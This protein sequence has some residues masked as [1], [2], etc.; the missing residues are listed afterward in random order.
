MGV[1]TCGFCFGVSYACSAFDTSV[2]GSRVL[3]PGAFRAELAQALETHDPSGD[4]VAGQHFVKLP[5]RAHRT[6]S[7]GVG[8][9]LGRGPGDFVVRAHRGRTAAFLR[10]AHA[11]QT[12]S[13]AVVV[14]TL[15]AYGS[16]PE[17]DTQAQDLVKHVEAGATH[18]IVAVLASSGPPSPHSPERFVSNL[19]GGNREALEWSADEIRSRAQ[20]VD[21]YWVEWA[22]VADEPGE[23]A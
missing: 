6:V 10:R 4:G 13:L 5:E 3:D 19:A 16:D 21:A 11:A 17:V 14:Y 9:R 18:V 22:V 15:D 23:T 12:D 8:S 1:V 2:V 20:G 7:G